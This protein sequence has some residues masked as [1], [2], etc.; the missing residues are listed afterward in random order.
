[1]RASLSSVWSAHSS[2][3]HTPRQSKNLTSARRRRSYSSAACSSSG[4]SRT[5]RRARSAA[6]IS[7]TESRQLYLR[8]HL[9]IL[10]DKSDRNVSRL[11]HRYIL[12]SLDTKWRR[13]TSSREGEGNCMVTA[14]RPRLFAHRR[15]TTALL[16]GAALMLPVV[17][18]HGDRPFLPNGLQFPN[19]NGTST[20]F[21]TDGGI[22]LTNPFFQS[23]GTNGRSCGSCHQP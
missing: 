5:S 18:L 7:A 6:V 2:G 10:H 9:S 11:S 4:A 16:A 12:R 19:E 8:F 23:L 20:T 17:A 22:D 21:S 1:S 3:G 14:K 13:R 15:L